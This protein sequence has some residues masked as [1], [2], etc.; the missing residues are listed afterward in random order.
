MLERLITTLRIIALP[1]II[2]FLLNNTAGSMIWAFL[3][4]IMAIFTDIVDYFLL[5]YIDRV[6]SFFDPFADKIL[7]MGLLLFFTIQDKFSGV[8]LSIFVGRDIIIA[9]LRWLLAQEESHVKGIIVYARTLITTQYGIVLALLLKELSFFYRLSL[10]DLFVNQVLVITILCAL[11][12]ALLSVIHTLVGYIKIRRRLK[13]ERKSVNESMVILA[14]KRSRGYYDVYRRHLLR[15]FSRRRNAPIIYLSTRRNMFGGISDK[16]KSIKNIIIAGG[17]GSFEG[18]LNYKPFSNKR[19]GFF[20]FGA[21]N[22]FYFYFYKGKRFEYLRSRFNFQEEQLDILEL[23]WENG[24][25]QTILVAAGIDAEVINLSSKKRTQYGL[26]DYFRGGL[27]VLI[28]SNSVFHFNCKVDDKKYEWKN[29]VNLT[30]GKIPNYGLGLKC[31]IGKVYPDDGLVYGL[32]CINTHSTFFN[33]P[34][35]LWALLLSSFNLNHS[36]ILPLH[37]KVIEVRSDNPFPIHAGG[38]YLGK[39]RWIKIKVVRKQKVLMI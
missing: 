38:E 4:M 15:V 2:Y 21:A 9:I 16:I 19:L 6:G 5:K 27:K 20:P 33:K 3:I 1:L 14:N 22:A 39:T 32:A 35:R 37:G 26:L 11:L 28:H 18:A 13:R 36:P 24:K 8:V 29:C 17:D 23:E 31:L 10:S 30:L 12:V 25:I 7:V 34:L